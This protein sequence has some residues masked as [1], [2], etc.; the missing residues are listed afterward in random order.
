MSFPVCMEMKFA[1]AH[2]QVYLECMMYIKR[3]KK[4]PSET[5]LEYS[6]QNLVIS[7]QFAQWNW[8]LCFVT[9][10]TNETNLSPSWN[11]WFFTNY[12]WSKI[13]CICWF[14]ILL[15]PKIPPMSLFSNIKWYWSTLVRASLKN[16][17]IIKTKHYYWLHNI[18]RGNILLLT[19]SSKYISTSVC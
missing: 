11:F 3:L 14:L 12:Y 15:M 19:F 18:C 7:F 6:V 13:C 8:W 4:V 16:K 2:D 17:V 5:V 10:F 1:A 9:N